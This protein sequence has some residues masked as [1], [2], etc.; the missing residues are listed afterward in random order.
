L[1]PAA[2]FF[3]VVLR[4]DVDRD[5]VRDVPELE[6]DRLVPLD[7]VDFRGVD[8]RGVAARTREIV[9]SSCGRSPSVASANGSGE[10]PKPGPAN[11]SG[12]RSL[13]CPS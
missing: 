5:A 3:A 9:S 6:R 1:L 12:P 13:P 4:L 2:F 8:F 10:Y 7:L 11:R